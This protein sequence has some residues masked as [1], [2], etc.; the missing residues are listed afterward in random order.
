M[1]KPG[2]AQSATLNLKNDPE[3]LPNMP[4][5]DSERRTQ[6]KEGI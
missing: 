3:R 5:T 6:G 1:K 2:K 4:S